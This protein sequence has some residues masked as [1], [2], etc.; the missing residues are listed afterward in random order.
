MN[1]QNIISQAS[2]YK[3][4]LEYLSDFIEVYKRIFQKIAEPIYHQAVI[5]LS[6]PHLV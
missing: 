2:P 5:K 3:I 1:E 6:I 4:S